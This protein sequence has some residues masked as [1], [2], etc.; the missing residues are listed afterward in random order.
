[1]ART[2]AQAL[3]SPSISNTN[4]QLNILTNSCGTNQAQDFL[5]VVNNDTVPI[6]VSDI[7]IKYWVDDTSGQAVVPAVYTGG[8]LT[9]ANGNPSCFH[10]VSGVT[11]TATSFAP[12][13]GPDASHQANWEITIS[14]TDPTPLAPGEVWGNLQ[15]AL[16]LGN[17]GNFSPGT[18]SWYSPCL[19]GRTYANDPHFAVYVKGNLVFSNG[20]AAPSCRAPHRL[21]PDLSGLAPAVPLPPLSS[22]S[23]VPAFLQWAYGSRKSQIPS[24]R[25]IIAN[26]NRS[27]SIGQAIVDILQNDTDLGR[28][29]VGISVL[30][31]LRT[32]AGMT[33]F[34][35]LLATPLPTSGTPSQD[36]SGLPDD[37]IAASK[38]QARA[39]EAASLMFTPASDQLLLSVI[40]S[41]QSNLVRARAIHQ[42]LWVHGPAG[43]AAVSAL[44][45]ADQKILLDQFD[46]AGGPG[47]YDERLANYL[48]LHPE[49]VPPP[50]APQPQ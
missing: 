10:Q 13:C 25:A 27:E 21:N 46:V 26:A 30:G 38:R 34:T 50:F 22:A 1:V 45:S 12:A 17:Y 40:G 29:L 24:A 3:S 16:H 48:A 14:S 20:L 28:N 42:Y 43:R 15:T 35:N 31:E 2:T 32:Q 47:T 37:Y 44:L 7:S 5:Q 49:I 18:G 33:F 9:N 41:T 6:A 4:L 8:C 23:D 11:A 36:L 39:V 19:T